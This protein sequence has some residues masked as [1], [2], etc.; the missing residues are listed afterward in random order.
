MENISKICIIC[1]ELKPLNEYYTHK[2]MGDGHLNKCKSCT[3]KQSKERHEKLILDPHWAEK[4]KN[5]HRKKYHR[6]G[7]RDKH[8]PSPQKKAEIM[9]RYNEKYPEKEAAHNRISGI[10]KQ[11][12]NE[13]HHWS[14]NEEH[15]K[16]VIELPIADHALL[17][18]YLFYD[19]DHKM[20]R[21]KK[22]TLL[23]TKE[24][25]LKYFSLVKQ[26]I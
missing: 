8:K 20:Y 21:T 2:Q 15:Y 22:G 12:G 5:R 6:L 7:Y 17:H 14:Y 25:H 18:R 26:L 10:K 11:K 13:L 16:D 24:L 9:K 19:Q 3:K 23:N 4:E 1:N